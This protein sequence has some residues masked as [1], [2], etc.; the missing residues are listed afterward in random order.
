MIDPANCFTLAFRSIGG[1]QTM[2]I[3]ARDLHAYLQIGRDFSGWIR[4]RIAQYHFTEDQDFEVFSRTGENSKVGRPSREYLIA[5]DMAKELAMVERTELGKAV[6]RYFIAC[7]KKL[8]GSVVVESAVRQLLLPKPLVWERR[9]HSGFYQALADMSGL[10]CKGHS[11]GTP[12]LFGKI[13]DEWIYQMVMPAEVLAELKTRRLPGQKLHQWLSN[14]GA[15]LVDR[16]ID[17]V[18]NLAKSSVGYQDFYARCQR[19]FEKPGQLRMIYP[20]AA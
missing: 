6:R 11:S 4:G 13:T 18:A 9:F 1:E 7:E 8:L 5:I 12:L 15:L 10:P 17:L 2:A 3:N 20:Q 19:A 14:G 16:Q